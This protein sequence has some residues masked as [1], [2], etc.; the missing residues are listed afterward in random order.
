KH[1]K[2]IPLGNVT[3]QLFAN[4]YLD[5]LDQFVTRRL[6]H[7]A[8]IR[9][10]DD[11]LLMDTSRARLTEALPAIQAF[12]SEKLSLELHPQKIKFRAWHQGIDFLGYVHF[13]YFRILRTK[14]K[15]R[16]FAKLSKRRREAQSGA[17]SEEKFFQSQ[18]SYL[19]VLS[20]ARTRELT[21]RVRSLRKAP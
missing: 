2:G 8:Y 7:G 17:I 1:G 21:T 18:Q 12:L 5:P 11:I 6:R 14:T 9:Y 3:S 15:R 10:M 19:G 13:P 20:H 4:V 16:M